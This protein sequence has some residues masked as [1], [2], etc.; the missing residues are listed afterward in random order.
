MNIVLEQS[1][2]WKE[3]LTALLSHLKKTEHAQYAQMSVIQQGI[4]K[5][6]SFCTTQNK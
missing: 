5:W 6:L 4:T 3:Q 1:N 2:I